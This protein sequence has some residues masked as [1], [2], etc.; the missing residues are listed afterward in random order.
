MGCEGRGW[1]VRGG[2]GMRGDGWE[3]GEV[4]LMWVRARAECYPI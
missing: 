3:G 2:G 4:V 1:D